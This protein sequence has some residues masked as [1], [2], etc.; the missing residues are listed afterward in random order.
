MQSYTFMGNKCN[1]NTKFNDLK[2]YK[3][4]LGRE[5]SFI[6]FLPLLFWG[7]QRYGQYIVWQNKV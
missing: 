7:V 2:Q 3:F 5:D 4:S 6:S 1:V